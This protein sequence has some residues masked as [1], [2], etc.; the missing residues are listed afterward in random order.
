MTDIEAHDKSRAVWDDMAPGWERNRDYMWRTTKHVAEWLVEHVQAKEGDTILD[1]AGG[2][3][4][5]GFLAGARVGPSGKIIETD[6]A[7]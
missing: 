6:F 3:G 7:P 2:P 1:L 4:D 5:N